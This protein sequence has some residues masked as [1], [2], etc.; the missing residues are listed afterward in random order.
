MAAIRGSGVS[1]RTNLWERRLAAT[2]LIRPS[3][4]ASFFSAMARCAALYLQKKR[5]HA[6]GPTVMVVGAW[7][8]CARSS[9]VRSAATHDAKASGARSERGRD[10][11]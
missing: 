1:P 10:A 7:Y 6:P 2:N 5:S 3:S 9:V 8:R 4:L 11:E